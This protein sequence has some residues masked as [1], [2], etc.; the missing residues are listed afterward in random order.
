MRFRLTCLLFVFLISC[1]S[2]LVQSGEAAIAG[3]V[4]DPSTATGTGLTVEGEVAKPVKLSLADLAKLPHKTVQAKGHDG[5]ENT[6]EGVPLIDILSAA[7]V[8]FGEQLG[9]QNLALFLLVGAA[10]GYHAVFA[11]PELDPAY[12]DRVVILADKI[13]GKPFGTDQGPLRI[14]VPDEK[15]QARWVRQVTTFTIMRAKPAGGK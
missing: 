3:I 8:P 6:Y 12:T 15:R 9:G 14:V 1:V 5:K 7:G 2:I 4:H 11:L 10:D 13:D